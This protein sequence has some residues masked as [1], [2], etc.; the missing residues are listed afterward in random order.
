MPD[1][2]IVGGVAGAAA[3]YEIARAGA[4]VTLLEQRR[5]AAMASRW[6][7]GDAIDPKLKGGR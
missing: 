1:V 6:T 7:L 5:L 4:S 3:A 2:I